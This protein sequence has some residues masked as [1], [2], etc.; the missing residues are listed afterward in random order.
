MMQALRN[1]GRYCLVTF[2]FAL[3]LAGAEPASESGS[4]ALSD[5]PSGHRYP[6]F[7]GKNL[8]GWNVAGCEVAVENGVLLL[9]SG[10]GFVWTD[11]KY[12]DFI[13]ELEWR[14]LKDQKWDSGIYI[15]AELPRDG[16]KWPDKHQVNLLEGHEG[17]LI[18]FSTAKS[19]GLVVNGQWNRLRLVVVGTQ[20]KM[21]I[22]GKPAWVADGIPA[23]KGYVGFQSEV[24]LGG[25]FEFRSIFI[26]EIGYRSLFNGSDLTGWEGADQ[27]AAKCWGVEQEELICSGAPGP[28]LRSKEQFSDFNLRLE[29]RTMNGGNS[30]V[31][32]RVPADGNHHGPGS[33]VEIQILDDR[34]EQYRELK[35]YQYCGSVYGIAPALQRVGKPAGEWNTL[36][37]NCK[38]TAYVVTHNGV[39]IVHVCEEAF[40]EIRQRLREGYLGLQNHSEKVWFRNLRLGP[41]E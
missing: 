41:G 17:N 9:K 24:P 16:K 38:G 18:G 19:T 3:P 32:C 35:P 13:L 26:T 22:N 4:G 30:G 27:D 31:Y 37:I 21:E 14:P 34:A 28:W 40:P 8:H 7:N 2:A 29:Y 23:E 20:A 10:D 39:V 5:S 12:R 1:Y 36:E 11:H 6:L 25:Q 33:G 15:R